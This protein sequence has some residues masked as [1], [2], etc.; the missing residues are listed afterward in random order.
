MLEADLVEAEASMKK[1]QKGLSFY[2][3]RS[4]GH[5]VRVCGLLDRRFVQ[6]GYIIR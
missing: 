4:A 2:R 3:L 1:N 6:Y 5:S